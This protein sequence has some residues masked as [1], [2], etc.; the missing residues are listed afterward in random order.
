MG[1]AGFQ[2]LSVDEIADHV[3]RFSLAALGKEQPLAYGASPPLG[4]RAP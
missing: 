1:D 4:S 2:Q 3:T